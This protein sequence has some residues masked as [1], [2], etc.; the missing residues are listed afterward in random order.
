MNVMV[1]FVSEP[2]QIKNL[3]GRL[4]PVEVSVSVSELID[5]FAASGGVVESVV[6]AG[7]SGVVEAGVAGVE[8]GS[9]HPTNGNTK[10]P[11]SIAAQILF[12]AQFL[13]RK[14]MNLE[15]DK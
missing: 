15:I 13:L 1:R 8:L 12:I 4:Q 5:Y 10:V 2:C 3:E 7:V 14:S 9:L 6:G 11:K